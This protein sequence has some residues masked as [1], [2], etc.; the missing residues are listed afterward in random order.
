MSSEFTND[1]L[2]FLNSTQRSAVRGGLRPLFSQET[3]KAGAS[4][5]DSRVLIAD[6]FTMVMP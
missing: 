3:V 2:S 5:S 1:S 6:C 4:S